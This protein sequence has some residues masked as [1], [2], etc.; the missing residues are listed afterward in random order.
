MIEVAI[1]GFGFS[2]VPLLR[3]LERTATPFT[4][5]TAEESS[6]W[7]AL[8]QSGRLDFD[9][10]SSY[11]TSFYSFDLTEIFQEDGYPN[12]REYYQV[13]LKWRAYYQ[14]RI[15]RDEVIRVDNFNDHS[16]IHTKSEQAISARH[17][18]FATGFG[19]AIL[20]DLKT[21]SP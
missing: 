8:S 13:H 7:D 5:I 16:V 11:L 4:I 1:V 17:V 18:V 12:A 14:D 6:V 15:V 19:R 21:K 9:L 2:A 3:E 20:R 10:V